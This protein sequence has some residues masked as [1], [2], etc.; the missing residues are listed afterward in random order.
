MFIGTWFLGRSVSWWP[1]L[2]VAHPWKSHHL[3]WA[4]HHS[5]PEVI[6][7]SWNT[8]L[9]T[10]N[11]EELVLRTRETRTD[12]SHRRRTGAIGASIRRKACKGG[13]LLHQ[14]LRAALLAQGVAYLVLFLSSVWNNSS[15]HYP[16]PRRCPDHRPVKHLDGERK[17]QGKLMYPDRE[18]AR[19]NQ[20]SFIQ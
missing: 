3:A 4:E 1:K 12:D 17:G 2:A 8:C 6:W 10:Q 13:C 7:A 20:A 11:G 9:Y 18:Q 15:L 19:R 5:P 14:H 16:F